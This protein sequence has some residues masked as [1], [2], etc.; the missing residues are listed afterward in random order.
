MKPIQCRFNSMKVNYYFESSISLLKEIVDQ[1]S[2]LIITDEKV[3]NYYKKRFKNWNIFILKQ[4]ELNKRQATVD[5][6]INR[7]IELEVNR[8][9]TLVGV[10]G[11]VITDLTGFIASIYMRGINFGFVPTTL[12]SMV[13]ASIGGKN[14][15][16]VG[17]Y[18][19][20]VG[21]IR[22]PSFILFDLAFLNTL[23]RC[24]WKNGFA[25]IIKHACVKDLKMF[26][27]LENHCY[28][29]YKKRK[30]FLHQ[31]IRRNVILKSKIVQQDEYEN[32]VRRILNFGHTLGHSL[33]N[34]YKLSHG[35]AVAIG[36]ISACKVSE[37]ITGF[38]Q[39]K[40]IIHLI[41]KYELPTDF[42]FDMQKVFEVLK[43]D[44]KGEKG[45]KISF[46]MLEKIGKGMVK[47]IPLYQL[48]K[49]METL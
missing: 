20:L 32:N 33:E 4:G 11:G 35:Q 41:D 2:S 45:D 21:V 13:D 19:N 7:L 39:T 48:A 3:F 30:K 37:H 25:E 40:R 9:S 34:Q 5:I 27:E 31:L 38:G 28:E 10:G 14:G 44:K 6:I 16:N 29:T 8:K 49:I 26:R 1:K 12:L 24:E 22:Q 15:I 43:M 36:M 18:K 42:Q 47:P 23:P 46:V 17:L